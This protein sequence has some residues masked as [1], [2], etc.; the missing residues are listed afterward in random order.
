LKCVG[1]KRDEDVRSDAMIELVVDGVDGQ[2]ALEFLERLLDFGELAS[3]LPRFGA[4]R[5]DA[6]SRV[7]PPNS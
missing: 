3:S 1:K 4:D 6:G 2:I 7:F 5:D